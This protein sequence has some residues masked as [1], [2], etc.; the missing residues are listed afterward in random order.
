MTGY[1]QSHRRPRDE[2][3]RLV[4]EQF[5][6]FVRLATRTAGICGLDTFGLPGSI[7]SSQ[8]Q[9]NSLSVPVAFSGRSTIPGAVHPVPL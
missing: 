8:G 9:A 1:R 7:C 6:F 5:A 2:R 3:L 4:C